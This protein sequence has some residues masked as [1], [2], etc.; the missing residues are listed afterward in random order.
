MNLFYSLRLRHTAE[1]SVTS[2]SFYIFGF[3]YLADIVIGDAEDTS[4]AIIICVDKKVIGIDTSSFFIGNNRISFN[5]YLSSIISMR[6][7]HVAVVLIN[8]GHPL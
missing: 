4:I 5:I 6:D 1:I 7:E 2:P 3:F 8:Q